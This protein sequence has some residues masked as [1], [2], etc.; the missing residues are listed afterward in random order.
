MIEKLRIVFMGTPEFAA[1]SLEKLVSEN[2]NVVGCFTNQDK[3]SGRGMKLKCSEVKEF[4]TKNNIEV[5]QPK[6]IRN[7]EE[8][9]E[10]LKKWNPN[11]IIVVAYGK[12]LPKE[13]LE[14]P[15]YGCINVHGSLLPKYRGSAP[16]QWSIINGEE[17]T[18]ITTMFM[19]EGMDTGDMLLKSEVDINDNDNFEVLYNKLKDVGA[20]I[21]IK[22]LNELQN[23]TLKRI[24]QD[25]ALATYAP[26][27]TRDMTKI[28]FNKNGIE[29][30][31]FVRGLSPFPGTY[32]MLDGKKYKVFDCSY[33]NEDVEVM[34]NKKVKE[35]GEVSYISKDSFYIKC[36]DGYIS[37]KN[38][39]AE[40][41]KRM[42]IS[43]F[44]AGNKIEIGSIVQ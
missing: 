6:K 36:K 23:G 18:G 21:L 24:K 1:C 42:N 33:Y 7:N 17:K 8:V 15:K 10:I 19:D 30:F 31:N 22:T 25:D 4:A 11:L 26:M 38:I 28:D 13:V 5:Y 37:I 29:I 3:P 14:Y 41:S 39:Q 2:F 20:S 44:L 35:N 12:I 40:N 34:M 27:I 9:L 43:S 16:I 32:F